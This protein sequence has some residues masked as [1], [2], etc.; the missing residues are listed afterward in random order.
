ML[1][2]APVTIVGRRPTVTRCQIF[3]FAAARRISPLLLILG[4]AAMLVIPAA[5]IHAQTTIDIEELVSEVKDPNDL[6]DVLRLSAERLLTTGRGP[7]TL[8]WDMFIHVNSPAKAAPDRREWETWADVEAVFGNPNCQPTWPTPEEVEVFD[9]QLLQ[10]QMLRE[11]ASDN[12]SERAQQQLEEELDGVNDHMISEVHL[13]RP[14]FNWLLVQELWNLNGQEKLYD[15]YRNNRSADPGFP[16]GSFFIK[17]AWQR[18]SE[19]DASRYHTRMVDGQRLGLVAFHIMAKVLPQW[20][21]AT[22][23]HVD[24]PNRELV[25]LQRD[26]YGIEA[27]TDQPSNA[28]LK[29]F[30]RNGL[31]PD[32]WS[33]YR[34]NG[35]QATFVDGQ[36]RPIILANS[37]IEAGMT[38]RSSCMTCHA[39][40]TIG[41]NGD[42]LSFAPVVGSPRESWFSIS[43]S[44]VSRIYLQL[45]FA[46]SQARAKAPTGPCEAEEST[47][48]EA[49]TQETTAQKSAEESESISAPA[50]E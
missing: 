25:T 30:K 28:L 36:G 29:S 6:A 23:E 37:V 38:A 11:F 31:D 44:P 17:A 7:A 5:E 16:G 45:D 4:L 18:V 35:T 32:I 22:W 10:Q 50:S 19:E 26:R 15:R 8:A 1:D 49:A 47:A 42:R 21:W 33:Q 9:D 3:D 20:F 48:E 46:A 40:T 43:S 34:L 13:N 2:L 14:A 41:E 12:F 39:R 27:G 24:N